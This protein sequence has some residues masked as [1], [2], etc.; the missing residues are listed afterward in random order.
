MTRY[1]VLLRGINVGGHRTVPMARLREAVAAAGF[2]DP[3][4]LLASGNLLVSSDLDAV[5]VRAGVEAAIEAGFGFP[6]ETV[7]LAQDALAAIV[8]AHPCAEA[9]GASIAFCSGPVDAAGH[10]RLTALAT[11]AET[12]AVA[13]DVVY[14]SFG[15]GQADSK[16]AAGI[17]KALAPLVVTVRNVATSAKLAGA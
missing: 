2:A 7:V 5:G 13:G 10:T 8:A 15:A 4:T 3:R 16:L 6:V 9:A 12:V 17:P 11:V 14:L 1:A